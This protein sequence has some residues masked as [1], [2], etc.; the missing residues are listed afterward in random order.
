MRPRRLSGN[1]CE[2]SYTLVTIS[3]K[4]TRSKRRGARRA[5]TAR[6]SERAVLDGEAVCKGSSHWLNSIGFGSLPSIRVRVRR[7]GGAN[8]D[9]RAVADGRRRQC[10]MCRAHSIQERRSAQIARSDHQRRG[11]R[12]SHCTQQKNVRQ[13]RMWCFARALDSTIPQVPNHG[14]STTPGLGRL[15]T[16]AVCLAQV[17]S[18]WPRGTPLDDVSRKLTPAPTHHF[19]ADCFSR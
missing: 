6:H 11:P 3:T 15:C 12:T 9:G 10:S 13:R 4:G 18:K 19:L 7:S 14:S 8:R 2:V 1:L 17:A 16:C 5:P